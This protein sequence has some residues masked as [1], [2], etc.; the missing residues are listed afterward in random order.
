M[1]TMKSTSYADIKAAAN[2]WWVRLDSGAVS[3][4][5]RAEFAAWLN[6]DPRHRQT[7]D[8]VC[9]LWGE[10]D[11]VKHRIDLPAS[12]VVPP[13]SVRRWRWAV[14]ALAAAC[15]SGWLIGPLSIW[16][17]A[18]FRTGLG[19]MR[20]IRLSDGSRVYLN[21]NSAL[22]VH[23]D[24]TQRQLDLLQGEAWFK[25]SPDKAKP[26]RVRAGE[27]VVTA[28]GTAFNIRL[29]DSQTEVSVTEHRVA[30]DGG[31]GRD[32][33][34]ELGEG[35][36]RVYGPQGGIGEVKAIDSQTVTAWQ[37]GKLV[38][39]NRPLGEVIEELNRYH[40]GYFAIADRSLVQR[41]VNGVFRT[42]QPLA[43]LDALETSLKLHSTRLGDYLVLLHR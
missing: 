30:I 28:L 33:H 5:E 24:G 12:A 32:F 39:Q 35:Y 17:Q 7:Y 27:G 21:G 41:R 16:V 13:K 14:P 42:D 10:L 40:R 37:R 43:V 6:A 11:A 4:R 31:R 23:I 25:V 34:A 2:A 15:L 1:V 3:A 26:F 29:F 9:A 38:F 18:D 36:Q 22:A 20:D 19:E 8:A